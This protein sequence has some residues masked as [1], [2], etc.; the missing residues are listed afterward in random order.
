MTTWQIRDNKFD[1]SISHSIAAPRE[2]VYNV[3]ANFEAYP[4]FINDLVS[5]RREGNVYRFVARAAILTIP[6]T[7]TVSEK[8]GESISFELVEGPVDRLTGQWL[9]GADESPDQTLV[10]L[11]IHVE[12]DDRG[13]WLLRMTG[14]YV[15]NKTNKLINAFSNRVVELQTGGVRPVAA[16]AAAGGLLD[17][18]K[19]L[20]ARLFGGPEAAPATAGPLTPARPASTFFRDEHNIQ[21]LEA[22]A[23]TMLP[24]DDFDAGVQDLGFISVAEMR[25]RYEGG[26]EALYRTALSAVDRMAQSMFAKPDFISLSPEERHAVLEAARQ[27]RVNGEVWGEVKPSS[28]FGSLWEDVVFLYCTHPDTWQR[29]GFPGPSF[30]AGGYKDY[31]SPQEFMGEKR[32]PN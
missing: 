18:L 2:V 16:P 10:T 28:F 21:T 24:P 30:D 15:Q 29:I 3:L 32:D 12:T 1:F 25:S 19:R 22:L 20:W 8:P 11:N 13:E 9:V 17:W 14:K 31:D 4:E 7:V 5:V 6:A 27:D 26:R 23:T